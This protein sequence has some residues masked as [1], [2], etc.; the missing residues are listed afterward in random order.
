M[1][2]T[3]CC[4][5]KRIYMCVGP[6]RQDGKAGKRPQSANHNSRST[7][8]TAPCTTARPS[9]AGGSGTS[10]APP[11]SKRGTK[12]SKRKKKKK[13]FRSE[14][15]ELLGDEIEIEELIDEERLDEMINEASNDFRGSLPNQLKSIVLQRKGF[16]T[17]K[18]VSRRFQVFT[19]FLI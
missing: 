11:S 7:R 4:N 2:L 13:A 5:D 3:L 12:K 15:A 19:P 1:N 16:S 8:A 18:Q 6:K 10:S 9:S 17:L 14:A